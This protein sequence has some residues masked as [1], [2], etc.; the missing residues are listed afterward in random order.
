MRM[1][2]E[3]NLNVKTC[4]G[5]EK[6]QKKNIHWNMPTESV[7]IHIQRPAERIC[8][9]SEGFVARSSL[10]FAEII[11]MKVYSLVFLVNFISSC[12]L[13]ETVFLFDFIRRR[14]VK[15][16][17][18]KAKRMQ[19]HVHQPLYAITLNHG[20]CFRITKTQRLSFSLS[21]S[22]VLFI[23]HRMHFEMW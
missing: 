17:S 1:I 5:D 14:N 21:L 4:K 7:K 20:V 12:V 13:G 11:R 18:Y 16:L 10:F 15:L 23:P 3:E 22:L 2:S 6:N 8:W 9:K 19:A